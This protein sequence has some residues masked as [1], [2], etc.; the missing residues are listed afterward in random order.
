M[1]GKSW[2]EQIRN[3]VLHPNQTVVDLRSRFTTNHMPLLDGNLEPM[4]VANLEHHLDQ[5]RS[6]ER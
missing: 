5:R 2:G 1:A 4:L 6:E 3:Y